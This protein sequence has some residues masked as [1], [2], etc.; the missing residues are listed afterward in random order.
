MEN[1][2]DENEIINMFRIIEDYNTHKKI[3]MNYH[4][5]QA[6]LDYVFPLKKDQIQF[7]NKF[8]CLTK[9][10]QE[11]IP[12]KIREACGI[13]NFNIKK[14]EKKAKDILDKL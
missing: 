14:L 10:I 12:E 4:D 13:K 1:K 3:Y 2:Y 8:L 9:N 11:N 7:S 6:Y 5:G